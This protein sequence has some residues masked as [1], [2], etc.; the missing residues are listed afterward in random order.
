MFTGTPEFFDTKRGVAGL[1][2][3]HDRIRFIERSGMASLRQPQINLK[4]FD[5]SRL[6]N[7]A[8]RLREL[9]PAEDRARLMQRLT[10]EVIGT[11]IDEVTKGFRGDVGIVPRQFLR[12]LVNEMDLVDENPEYLPKG[13]PIEIKED[14]LAPEERAILSGPEAS[15]PAEDDAIVPVED[16]W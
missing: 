14:S 2:P 8:V 4:P 10:D 16:A 1:P 9:Y 15:E 5:R 7:V 6:E 13:S 11:M 3:L 12:E